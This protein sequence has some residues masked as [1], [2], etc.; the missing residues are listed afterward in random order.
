MICDC[1]M[2]SLRTSKRVQRLI[3]EMMMIMTAVMSVTVTK[4][5]KRKTSRMKNKMKTIKTGVITSLAQAA[6]VDSPSDAVGMNINNR[7][8]V[9]SLNLQKRDVMHI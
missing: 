8:F 3:G 9:H 1:H 5:R 6:S 2:S 4:R 7:R